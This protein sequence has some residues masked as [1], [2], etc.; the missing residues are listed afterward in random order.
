MELKNSINK[1]W[2][3]WIILKSI[4]WKNIIEIFKKEKD[5]NLKPYLVSINLRWN[6][7]IIKT[8]KPIINTELLLLDDKIKEK[9]QKNIKKV[10]LDFEILDI[11]YT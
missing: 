7:V 9:S 11:R 10:W 5:M 4:I 6:N 1:R 3:E 8:N 2:I